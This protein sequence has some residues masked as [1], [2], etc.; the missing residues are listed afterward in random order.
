MLPQTPENHM[1]KRTL[2]A[3][4]VGLLAVFA[5]NL[6]AILAGAQKAVNPPVSVTGTWQRNT[7]DRGP[8]VFSLRAD[9]NTLTGRVWEEGGLTGPAEIFD[10][11]ISADT[12]TFKY[13]SI[14]ERTVAGKVLTVTLTG[15]LRK[16]EIAFT[17]QVDRTDTVRYRDLFSRGIAERFSVKRSAAAVVGKV[18]VENGAPRPVFEFRLVDT[19]GKKFEPL[20][21]SS[22]GRN[23]GFG[24]ARQLGA[25]NLI[26]GSAFDPAPARGSSPPGNSAA[27][28]LR[29]PPGEYR[30]AVS[31]LPKGYTLKSIQAGSADLTAA[32]LTIAAD[33]APSDLTITLRA[34][35]ESSW[36]KVGGR[37][38]NVPARVSR[39][40]SQVG[41]NSGPFLSPPT[42]VVLIGAA[43]S[44]YLVA[45]IATDGAFEFAAV[46]PG[47]YK[48]R[49]SPD[50]PWTL[51]LNLSV[52][53]SRNLLGL[54]IVAPDVQGCVNC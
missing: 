2:A 54:S 48:V 28:I 4:A 46:P 1:T 37:V 21:R 45:P 50:S 31:G 33:A 3:L 38:V 53:V 35:P 32:I 49:F 44:E 9:G 14:P 43:F 16:D 40:Y 7:N 5:P 20:T 51:P 27:F 52:P 23:G 42:S 24:F 30:P 8:W 47:D 25:D 36:V 13:R 18:V 41:P 15:K 26:A 19:R 29:L 11:R 10:G 34:N 22:E 6:A 17:S 12:L 39:Q